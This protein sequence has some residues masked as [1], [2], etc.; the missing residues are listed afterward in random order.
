MMKLIRLKV[1][2]LYCYLEN[3]T[4]VKSMLI[5]GFSKLLRGPFLPGIVSIFLDYS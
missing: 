3:I 2:L 5:Q 1:F 4:S